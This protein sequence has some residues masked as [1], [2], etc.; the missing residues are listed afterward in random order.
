M[1]VNIAKQTSATIKLMSVKMHAGEVGT[2]T[3]LVQQLLAR[4]F[5]QWAHFPIAPVASSG[6]DNALY[7]LGDDMVVRLPRVD[8]AIAQVEKEQQWL[9]RLA[10]PVIV[11]EA[12]HAINEVL[13]DQKAK[14][15]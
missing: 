2:D 1:G 13:A 10:P 15:I 4:Q 11:A 6:T 14:R 3:S 5:P 12:T 7:R 8:W 9:P